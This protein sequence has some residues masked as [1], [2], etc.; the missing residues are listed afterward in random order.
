MT[1]PTP[2]PDDELRFLS[3]EWVAAVDTAL[4]TVI[5][6]PEATPA[7]VEYRVDDQGQSRRHQIVLGPDRLGARRPAGQPDVVL[8]MSWAIAW[9]VNQGT[10][11]AQ[12]AVLDGK[13]LLTGDPGV[14]LAH[15]PQLAAMDDVLAPVRAATT[16]DPSVG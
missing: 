7:V 3:D 2:A 5:P 10:I 6:A 11:S 14:L 13:I 8:S 16:L 12:A 9:A 15:Q 1:A 4:S